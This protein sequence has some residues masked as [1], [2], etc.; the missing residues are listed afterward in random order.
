MRLGLHVSLSLSFF[1]TSLQT[2]KARA[3]VFVVSHPLACE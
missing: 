3:S 1:P 2:T